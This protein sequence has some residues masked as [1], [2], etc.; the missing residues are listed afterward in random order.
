MYVFASTTF[1]AVISLLAPFGFGKKAETTLPLKCERVAQKGASESAV[2]QVKLIVEGVADSTPVELTI[3]RLNGKSVFP[4]PLQVNDKAEVVLS[5]NQ[6]PLVLPLYLYSEYEAAHGFSKGEPV[7]YKVI[8]DKN[9]AVATVTIIPFPNEAKDEN[10]HVLSVDCVSRD[11]KT[12]AMKATGFEPY[13]VVDLISRSGDQL[14]AGQGVASEKGEF[15]ITLTPTATGKKGGTAT[16]E[17]KGQT[18]KN[19]KVSFDWGQA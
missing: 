10:G 6:E 1:V 5:A 4:A 8:A 17:I 18:T 7:Q 3:I 15:F 13:E 19:L 14:S 2:V 12:F 16:Y 9:K 11:K